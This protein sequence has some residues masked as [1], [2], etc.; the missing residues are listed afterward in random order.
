MTPPEQI[1]PPD[2]VEEAYLED[3]NKTLEPLNA[4]QRIEWTLNYL[5]GNHIMTSSFGIQGALMLHMVTRVA[6][7]IPV[8]LVDT[9]Y[10]FPETYEFIDQLCDRLE[11]NLQIYRA[12]ESPAWQE[13]RYGRLWEQGLSG[14]EHYNLINKVEPLQKALKSLD[15]GSW[16]AGLRRQQSQSRATLPVVRVQNRRYKIHPVID[17]H[18]RDVHRYLQRYN[19]PYHPLWEKGYVSVGD[20]HT[21]KPLELGMSEEQT[22][23]FG[24]KRECGIH[25]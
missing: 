9:G 20:I 15:A 18:N 4:E 25:E 10:L 22:R 24:L 2:Q 13:S 3:L 1:T 21:S 12:D 8:V 19:L 14:I 5:P 23:F 17:W 7:D 6:S 11:L 16:F